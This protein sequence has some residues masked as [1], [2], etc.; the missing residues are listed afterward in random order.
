M[1]SK[2]SKNI[3][4]I[5]IILSLLLC[6]FLNNSVLYC[7]VNTN[8]KES[9]LAIADSTLNVF[10]F[11]Y[12][13]NHPNNNYVADDLTVEYIWKK[14]IVF[15]ANNKTF[16]IFQ[17]GV[18]QTHSGSLFLLMDEANMIV[19]NLNRLTEDMVIEWDCLK[20]HNVPD[21]KAWKYINYSTKTHLREI[22]YFPW[23]A[24]SD[25]IK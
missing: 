20:K 16:K 10:L 6:F 1:K 21:K 8:R 23:K 5:S 25:I 14:E 2:K 7:Q 17:F 11:K 18:N 12:L 3:K 13:L 19:L 4:K 22:F 9:F 15:G 24:Q